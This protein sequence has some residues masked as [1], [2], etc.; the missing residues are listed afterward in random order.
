MKYKN[1]SR[2]KYVPPVYKPRQDYKDFFMKKSQP[3]FSNI[4]EVERYLE[5]EVFSEQ[6]F[7]Q[8]VVAAGKTNEVSYLLAYD[9]ITKTLINI[10]YEIDQSITLK[11]KKK[12]INVYGY[13]F[14]EVGFMIS[15]KGKAMFLEKH[16]KI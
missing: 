8:N 14:L 5:T 6:E 10:L 15:L 7:I 3:K 4:K 2:K 1:K 9:V 12:R 13:F 11:R 16:I